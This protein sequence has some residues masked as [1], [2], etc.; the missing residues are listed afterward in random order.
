MNKKIYWL[1]ELSQ[2][3]LHV[4]GKKC[5]N[6]GE[7]TQKGLPVPPGFAISVEAYKQ[8]F[9]KTGLYE[10]VT[11]LI[12][13]AG[14][15]TG[16]IDKLEELS[17]QIRATVDRQAMPVSLKEEIVTN[18]REL[19]ARLGK[20]HLKVAVRSSGAVSMPGSY[21]TYLYV[22]GDQ[23]VIDKVI[24]V[25]SS[26]FNA[27]SLGYRLEKGMSLMDTPI[28]VAVI[29]MVNAKAAGV[30]FTINPI[31]GDRSKMLVEANYGLGESVVSGRVEPDRFKLNR[32]LGTAE[33]KMLGAKEE[34]CIHDIDRGGIIFR[35]VPEERRHDFCLE[36][37]ELRELMKLGKKVEAYF[38][39]LPQ[40][41]EWAF[42][43]DLPLGENLLLLQ[44]RPEQTY[45]ARKAGRKRAQ[46][47]DGMSYISTFLRQGIKFN[48]SAT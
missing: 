27:R 32:A 44:A 40:D 29:K 25:W 46:T 18:Y 43:R 1:N 9:S 35:P 20:E 23:D 14:E 30:L 13:Q 45:A 38:G 26:T 42:D 31:S 22:H 16:R 21:E 11:K 37:D 39:N 47:S 3:D 8:F 24:K 19:S 6:L 10:T 33:E 4:V 36:D 41:I 12:E 48:N 15:V 34:E 5:A 7:M 17:R 2:T 28:G